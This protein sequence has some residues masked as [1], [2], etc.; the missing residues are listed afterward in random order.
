MKK[1]T[2]IIVLCAIIVVLLGVV[3]YFVV[4]N[5]QEKKQQKIEAYRR[6]HSDKYIKF[7]DNAGNDQA[8]KKIG[9]LLL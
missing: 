1:K 7:T 2:L 6:A 9:K 3:A 8:K 5:I 4:N